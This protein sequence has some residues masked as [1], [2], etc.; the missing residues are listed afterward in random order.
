MADVGIKPED[1][2]NLVTPQEEEEATASGN[3]FK[4]GNF[5]ATDDENKK[6]KPKQVLNLRPF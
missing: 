4:D 6:Q 1:I 2:V 3:R 5:K